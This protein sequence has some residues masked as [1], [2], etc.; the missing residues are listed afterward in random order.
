MESPTNPLLKVVDIAAVAAVAKKHNITLVVD[1]TFLSPY[2]QHPLSL[3][4][5]IVLHSI[6]KYINGHS[7]VIGGV[8][9]TSNDELATRIRF[10]QN[11]VEGGKACRL[12]ISSAHSNGRHPSAV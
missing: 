7:D 8:V 5:D 6:S 2:F 11:G 9:V 10:L 3:G 12:V 1:N 4:A